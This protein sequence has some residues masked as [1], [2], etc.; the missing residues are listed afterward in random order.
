MYV[1]CISCTV[2]STLYTEWIL[3][4][5]GDTGAGDAAG[6]VEEGLG[7]RDNAEPEAHS[8][9]GDAEGA[10]CGPAPLPYHGHPEQ[11]KGVGLQLAAN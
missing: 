10:W 7:V 3:D 6:W 9:E 8:P 1:Y 2:Q 4:W 11:V 5:G